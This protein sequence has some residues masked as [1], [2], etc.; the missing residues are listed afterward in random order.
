MKIPGF[1]KRLEITYPIYTANAEDLTVIFSTPNI[2]I[3]TSLL[4]DEKGNVVDVFTGWSR[5]TR[6]RMEAL[7]RSR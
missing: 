6:R 7:A 1:L 2:P 5:E 4:V 3:P